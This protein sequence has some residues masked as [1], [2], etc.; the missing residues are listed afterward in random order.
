MANPTLP[1][2]QIALP[3]HLAHTIQTLTSFSIVLG[4]PDILRVGS[5]YYESEVNRAQNIEAGVG[6][7]LPA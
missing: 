5:E 1:N 7:D 6:L 4:M 3:G 2:F